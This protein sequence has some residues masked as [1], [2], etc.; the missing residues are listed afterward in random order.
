[1]EVYRKNNSSI[2]TLELQ[3]IINAVAFKNY[4]RLFSVKQKWIYCENDFYKVNFF[5]VNNWLERLYIERLE[6]KYQEI[7]VLLKDSKNNW[8][9]VLFIMLSKSF[10]LKI[11]ATPFM[12]IANSIDF[13][14]IQKLKP[15]LKYLE[16]LFFGQAGLLQNNVQDPYYL[17]LQDEYV[18]L[19]QK[20]QLSNVSIPTVQ[21]FRLRPLNFPTIRLS[22][23]AKLYHLQSNLFSKIMQAKTKEQIY[24]LF[25]ITTSNYW[26]NHFTFGKTSKIS[27]KKISKALIDL[28]IINA[29][30]P[31][32]FSYL[33]NRGVTNKSTL[34]DLIQELAP[35]KNMIVQKFNDLQPIVNSAMHSQALLELKNNYC[36]KKK[37]LQCAIGNALLNRID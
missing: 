6:N 33:K 11:N 1:M 36:D 19:K 21:F 15:N 4:Q 5:T 16:A 17:K 30:I 18:F 37:C 14:V 32:K 12:A 3:N 28:I 2:P 35:E 10:G 9:A 8:E 34:L 23:L 25:N 7:K 27:R 22:Q 29:V 20:Y 31:L 24:D 26:E 13:S